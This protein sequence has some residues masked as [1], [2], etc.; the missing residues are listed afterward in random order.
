M[1]RKMVTARSVMQRTQRQRTATMESGP[2]MMIT[3]PMTTPTMRGTERRTRKRSPRVCSAFTAL[4]LQEEK[5]DDDDG[6]VDGDGDEILFSLIQ[7]N[8]FHMF[9]FL[10]K[11]LLH[12]ILRSSQLCSVHCYDT[13]GLT[14]ASLSYP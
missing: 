7:K 12:T 14:P 4:E 3:T 9:S 1:R 10:S 6:G 5:Q 2:V 8:D 11:G 13:E